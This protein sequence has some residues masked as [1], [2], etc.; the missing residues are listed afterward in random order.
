MVTFP[1]SLSLLVVWTVALAL[2]E[3]GTAVA[4]TSSPASLERKES[5]SVVLE[6]MAAD[7]ALLY[8]AVAAM[9]PLEFRV[10]LFPFSSMVVSVLLW[11]ER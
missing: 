2:E 3:D 9:A 4:V 11:E 6:G 5:K 7:A 1:S 10:L 8:I